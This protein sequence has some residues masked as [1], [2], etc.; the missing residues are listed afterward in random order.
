MDKFFKAIGRFFKRIWQWIKNTAWVQPLLIV[1]II[2]AII[3]SFSSNS[4]LMTWIKSLSD[5]DTTGEF[6]DDHKV[7]FTGVFK[8][9]YSAPRNGV[10]YNYPEYSK[11]NNEISGDLLKDYD[12]YTVVVFNNNDNMEQNVKNFYDRVLSTYPNAQKHFYVVDFRED[13]NTYTKWD[14]KN[15]KWVNDGGS[16]LY[17]Y[18]YDKLTEYYN[19]EEDSSTGNYVGNFKDYSAAFESVYGYPAKNQSLEPWEASGTDISSL[20]SALSMPITVLFKGE[21]IIDMRIAQSSSTEYSSS[22]Y[23]TKSAG[24]QTLT[25]LTQMYEFVYTSAFQEY[26]TAKGL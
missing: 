15:S 1:V 8:D 5:P 7:W 24:D 26:A 16:T 17:E 12:G 11:P 10:Y 23:N 20:K 21:N 13:R 18:L 2:F 4:P 14:E 3:F 22:D 25:V 19:S 9:V 6:Y